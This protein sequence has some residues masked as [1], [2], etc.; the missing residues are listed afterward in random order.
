MTP[1][2]TGH[3]DQVREAG[4]ATKLLKNFIF[5]C[6]DKIYRNNLLTGAVGLGRTNLSLVGQLGLDRFSYCLSSNPKVASP[7]LLGSTAN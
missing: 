3:P 2:D 1:G 5:G 6:T 7:I 4:A